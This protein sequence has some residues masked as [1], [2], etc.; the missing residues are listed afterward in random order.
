MRVAMNVDAT[1]RVL[2]AALPRGTADVRLVL[3]LSHDQGPIYDR[4]VAAGHDVVWVLARESVPGL[5]AGPTANVPLD[6]FSHLVAEAIEA[7]KA[8]LGRERLKRVQL[9]NE[10]FNPLSSPSSWVMSAAHVERLIGEGVNRLAVPWGTEL[11]GPGLGDGNPQAWL[12][13][14]NRGSVKRVC[15]QLYG[16]TVT[17][18]PLPLFAPGG[19]LVAKIAGYRAVL[20]P[21]QELEITELGVREAEFG[22]TPEQQLHR[23][24]DW[25]TG[26]LKDC[27]ASALARVFA[28]CADEAMVGGYGLRAGSNGSVKPAFEAIERYLAPSATPIDNAAEVAWR[29]RWRELRPAAEYHHDW[30]LERA[31][32]PKASAWGPPLTEQQEPV[33]WKGRTYQGRV[34]KTAGLVVWDEAVNAAQPVGWP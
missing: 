8:K 29:A 32:R 9:G 28:F 30:G 31:W 10:P 26:A 6:M 19:P 5:P 12:R 14:G 27:E 1:G 25:W 34:F 11:W 33:T 13:V 15:A 7:Y 22:G 16:C 2:P 21:G 17:N 18:G 23:Q 4:W 20:A 24:A 3:D